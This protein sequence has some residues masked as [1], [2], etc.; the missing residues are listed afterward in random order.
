MIRPLTESHT[1]RIYGRTELAEVRMTCWTA[2]TT[3]V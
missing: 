3:S 1:R 2:T